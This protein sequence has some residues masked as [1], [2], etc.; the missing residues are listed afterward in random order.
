MKF[1]AKAAR[2]IPL[3]KRYMTTPDPGAN[4]LS[5]WLIQAMD[6]NAAEYC[7]NRAHPKMRQ[8]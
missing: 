6:S 4:I 5:I 7:V 1:N 8:L 3:K 2:S